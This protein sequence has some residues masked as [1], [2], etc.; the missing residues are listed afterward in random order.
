[1]K[2]EM[3]LLVLFGFIVFAI[4]SSF[5]FT[6]IIHN[7]NYKFKEHFLDRDLGL[8]DT[9]HNVDLPLTTT[10]ECENKC[11]PP[12]RCSITGEQC[13]SD[14]DCCGCQPYTPKEIAFIENKNKKADD[15]I[16]GSEEGFENAAQIGEYSAPPA[17]FQGVDMWSPAFNEGSRLFVKKHAAEF[18]E[19]R[20]RYVQGDMNFLLKFPE[21]RTLSGQFIE[22]GAYAITDY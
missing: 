5:Y 20:Y 2:R 18:Q 9:T 7:Y 12:N 10:Y 1:M 11:M 16:V 14:I 19:N 21:R 22:D 17:Y 13:S 8:P 6:P 4:I 3:Q 15:K